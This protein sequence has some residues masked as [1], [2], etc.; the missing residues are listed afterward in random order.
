MSKMR[1]GVMDTAL[2]SRPGMDSLTRAN[3][4]AAVANRFDSFWVP[5]HLNA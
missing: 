1:V 4:M 2:A 3:Y 5:D